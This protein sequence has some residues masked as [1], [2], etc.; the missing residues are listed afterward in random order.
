MTTFA[1]SPVQQDSQSASAGSRSSQ[2]PTFLHGPNVS[3]PERTVSLAAG[4]LL[5]L[6]GLARH[7][8]PGL[9]IASVGGAMLYRGATG[10]CHLYGALNLN[11]A[12]QQNIR[13]NLAA[14]ATHIAHSFLINKPREELYQYWRNFSN[15]PHIMSHLKEVRVLDDKRSHW[16]TSAPAVAGG[17]IEWDAQIIRDDPNERI[18]WESL[19]GSAIDHAGSVRFST[20][21]GD[22]GTAVTVRLDYVVPGGPLG[23]MVAKLFGQAPEQQIK[24]D[25]RCFKRQM[26][27]GE[28]VSI[29]GQPRG[30]CTGRGKR[31][32]N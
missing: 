8:F 25:L 6:F 16:V 12:T 22:R 11:T 18:D 27:T 17:S 20:P 10:H 3:Q 30:T 26:E 28:V 4:S 9:L 23:R 5:A 29:S 24:E 14:N 7:D 31:E 32:F 13:D 1:Q 19:P 15:L 2:P 21:K